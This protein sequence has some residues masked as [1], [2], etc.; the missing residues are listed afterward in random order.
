[1]SKTECEPAKGVTLQKKEERF[2]GIDPGFMAATTVIGDKVVGKAGKEL[3]KVEE[4]M[5]NLTTG[6]ITYL[7][8]STGGILG[9]GDK[10]FAIP[11]ER[12]TFDAEERVFYLDID[13]RKL[14]KM[15]GFDKDQWPQQAD[16]PPAE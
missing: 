15:R 5:L 10:F 14:K 12:L 11:L 2:T 6:T 3:G 4:V 7:V 8:L 9:I 13:R 1:M 16:W